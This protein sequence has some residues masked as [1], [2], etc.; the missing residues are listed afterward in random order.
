MSADSSVVF[1]PDGIRPLQVF[2][3]E[4]LALTTKRSRDQEA[5]GEMLITL[6]VL[7]FATG[8]IHRLVAIIMLLKEKKTITQQTLANFVF[9][10]QEAEHM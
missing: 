9:M 6:E 1:K 7:T 5:D 8:H 4:R 2:V 3:P 10:A